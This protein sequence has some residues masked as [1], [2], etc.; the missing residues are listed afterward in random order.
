M[1]AAI[2]MPPILLGQRLCAAAR[3]AMLRSAIRID[4]FAGSPMGMTAVASRNAVSGTA[5]MC[6]QRRLVPD[7]PKIELSFG[8]TL[9]AE[10][11]ACREIFG[12]DARRFAKLRQRH[13]RQH[14]RA[15]AF[16]NTAE[17]GVEL[18]S[19]IDRL[20]EAAKAIMKVSENATA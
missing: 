20:E 17:N 8:G 13:D 16:I 5:S 14:S 10:N 1:E 15:Q 6:S 7:D 9:H 4:E 19:T 18:P 2:T 3:D 12:K 11:R